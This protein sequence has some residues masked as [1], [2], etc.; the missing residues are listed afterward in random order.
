M[1]ALKA[2]DPQDTSYDC[3]WIE[4]QKVEQK[5]SVLRKSR[6]IQKVEQK[7]S[8]LR[9]SKEQVQFFLP[10]RF[11]PTTCTNTFVTYVK[12]SRVLITFWVYLNES[13]TTN[14]EH[15]CHLEHRT[16]N[17]NTKSFWHEGANYPSNRA[18]LPWM[19]NV[20]FVKTWWSQIES[21][22]HS[23]L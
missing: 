1:F 2:L 13:R 17:R 4:K 11:F 12:R 14:I 6:E 10:L 7:S 23:K 3:A 18:V 16:V 5:I 20:F 22:C 21:L 8:V 15:K 19:F 9:K